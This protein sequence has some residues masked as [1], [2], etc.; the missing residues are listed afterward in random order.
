MNEVERFKERKRRLND[1]EKKN[2][3][4]NDIVIDDVKGIDVDH[5]FLANHQQSFEDRF[6]FEFTTE[7]SE[8][9]ISDF[10]TTMETKLNEERLNDLIHS[11]RNDVLSSII[12]PF[13]LGGFVSKF[14][15]NG[16]NVTTLHNF[17]EGVTANEQDEK[18]YIEWEKSKEN[19]DRTPYDKDI[20]INKNGEPVYNRNGEVQKTYFNSTKK[21]DIYKTL[22]EGTT[23]NDGYTGKSLGT[24]QQNKIE[25]S[26][27]IDLEH[28]TSVKE[29]ENDPK[30]HLYSKGDKESERLQDR[31]SLARDDKNLTITDSSINRSKGS[32]DLLIWANEKNKKDP[33]K[34]NAEYYGTDSELL[35]KEYEKSKKLLKKEQLSRQ[36]K[37]QGTEVVKTSTIEG[38]KM[39]AQQALGAVLCEFFSALFDE[40]HDIF[41]SGFKNG[42]EDQTFFEILKNRISRINE[43]IANKWKDYLKAF[44]FGSISGFLSNIATVIINMFIRTG[45]RIVRIIR[46]GFFSLL[47]AIKIL[48]FPPDGFTFI[49]AA[50]EASKLIASGFV[51]TGGILLE[52]HIDNLI[53]ATPFLEP[54]ADIITTILVGGITGLAT[55]FIVF[56]IDKIDLFK[57]NANENQK[58]ISELLGNE[59]EKF[60]EKG[61]SIILE[62]A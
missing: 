34:T 3:D 49:Q 59:I 16:G 57:V 55:T 23:I 20:K 5:V 2:Y 54:I 61:T 56:A 41:K 62:L 17:K 9:E 42:F 18:R 33:Q 1:L 31:V 60:F 8:K 22:D 48:C 13:G 43:K 40:I 27:P 6:I 21:K 30:N 4:F 24:K 38:A 45:K 53:K 50:H 32:K 51:I 36:F 47:K 28:I 46:E 25:K 11:C 26:N 12:T 39:G 29:I 14:D 19:F 35:K 58:K 10:L 7:V 37:K 52:Q 44:A 15:K